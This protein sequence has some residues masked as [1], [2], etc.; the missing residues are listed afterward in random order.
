[1]LLWKWT[2]P[3]SQTTKFLKT[4]GTLI[5]A[6][7]CGLLG[8]SWLLVR[9][10]T[11]LSSITW[12]NVSMSQWPRNKKCKRT[13]ISQWRRRSFKLRI[14]MPISW[15]Y[16]WLDLRLVEECRVW[17]WWLLWGLSRGMLIWSFC[18]S[19]FPKCQEALMSI[20]MKLWFHISHGLWVCTFCFQ[21]GCTAYQQS[22]RLRIR[23]F[24][25]G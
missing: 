19:G 23:Y 15:W 8:L 16:F 14:I 20:W 6:T 5:S 25:T 7:N 22:L 9:I 21:S 11:C 4:I 2:Q 13:W 1:M 24:L 10:H 18:L 17:L 3:S 12:W